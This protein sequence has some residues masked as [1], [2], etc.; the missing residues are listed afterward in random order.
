MSNVGSINRDPDEPIKEKQKFKETV[1]NQNISKNSSWL[2]DFSGYPPKFITSSRI[3]VQQ[4]LESWPNP[5]KKSQADT[6]NSASTIC[7]LY[8]PQKNNELHVIRDF[9]PDL[10]AS[11]H[12]RHAL[13]SASF[14][15]TPEKPGD[16]ICV[17]PTERN[18]RYVVD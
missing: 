18:R 14:K 17:D 10:V 11:L 4:L 5:A 13:G 15:A 12:K 16:Y 3:S 7:Y 2:L 1:E 9:L 8:N 6:I